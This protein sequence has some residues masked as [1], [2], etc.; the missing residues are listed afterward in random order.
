MALYKDSDQDVRDQY[1]V[2]DRCRFKNTIC[3]Y[4][5]EVDKWIVNITQQL[6]DNPMLGRIEMTFDC[7]DLEAEGWSRPPI[8]VIKDENG[9]HVDESST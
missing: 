4:T 9:V 3:K 6:R 8:Q 5:D 1:L 2:C 7:K